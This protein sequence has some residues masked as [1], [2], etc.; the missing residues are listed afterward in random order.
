MSIA[1]TSGSFTCDAAL[2]CEWSLASAT[3]SPTVAYTTANV[4]LLCLVVP[5]KSQ[6]RLGPAYTA[7]HSSSSGGGSFNSGSYS[8]GS[9]TVAAAPPVT[10]FSES[11][12]ARGLTA[13]LSS[14]TAVL[15][16][17]LERTGCRRIAVAAYTTPLPVPLSYPLIFRPTLDHR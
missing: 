11:L 8:N 13:S 14:Q 17:A 10:V 4:S 7:A 2:L 1:Y 9:A 16:E 3:A 15:R 12:C 5:C 6:H